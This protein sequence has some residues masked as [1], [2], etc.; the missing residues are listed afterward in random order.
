[1]SSAETPEIS[2]ALVEQLI[3]EQF[4]QWA[5]LPIR[6]VKFGG[7][8]NRTFH[9]GDVMNVRLPSAAHYALQVEKEQH[10]L[11][12][13]A[14]YLPL[15]IPAPLAIGRPGRG[16]P[17]H[18]SVYR[19]LPGETATHAPITDLGSFATTLGEFLAALQRIDARSGPPPGQHNF[20]RGGPLAVY[21]HETR[22]ALEAL[23]GRIDVATARVVWEV[24]L[25]SAWNNAPVWFHGDVASGNLLVEN[26]QLSAVIDFGTSGV[27]DPAC[28]L[29]I[30]WTMFDETSRAA[31]RDA[32]PLDEE[33]WARGRGW[34]L[35]KALIVAVE[36]P[37]TDRREIEKSRRVIDAV[38]SD[39]RRYG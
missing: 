22:R 29:S 18:W 5:D 31:F 39:H 32:L 7:W 25:G 2:T 16:Y 11:P 24:A 3:S 6:P 9:L 14:P 13:L 4:P 10:W 28:D 15:R 38:L 27:G 33:T 19:W 20:F 1:M 26:G 12:R 35:W 34:T 23:E 36:M 21:D 8:D 30:S 17:W 37:G